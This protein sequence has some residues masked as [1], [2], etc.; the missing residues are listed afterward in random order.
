MYLNIKNS[1]DHIK[2]RKITND[3][4]L[5]INSLEELFSEICQTRFELNRSISNIS[6]EFL[7]VRKQTLSRLIVLRNYI[8]N[9]LID[10]FQNELN[11]AR[12]RNVIESIQKPKWFGEFDAFIISESEHLC[13]LRALA[14]GFEWHI[15]HMIPLRG[16]L[17]CGLHCGLNLQVIPSY[18]NLYKNNKHI[19]QEPF[20]WLENV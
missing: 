5:I 18:I 15:D 1:I 12:S 8:R 9:V 14:T 4:L 6:P 2:N 19:Y 20:E 13:K 7:K 3:Q 11:T 16:S 10:N 17:A